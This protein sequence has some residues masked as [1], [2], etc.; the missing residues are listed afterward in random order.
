MTRTVLIPSS[1]T[2][3][4][5]NM[6]MATLKLGYIA[7]AAAIFNIDRLCI[8]PDLPREGSAQNWLML[9]SYHLLESY[10]RPALDQK[11]QSR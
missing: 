10:H 4:T 3:E 2:R 7:R 9:E 11:I 8:F 6:R 5:E 1:L